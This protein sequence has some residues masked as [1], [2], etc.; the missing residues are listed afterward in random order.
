MDIIFGKME[1]EPA[2]HKKK[3]INRYT[4]AADATKYNRSDM[5]ST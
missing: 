2:L 1:K 5:L 4:L 3:Y